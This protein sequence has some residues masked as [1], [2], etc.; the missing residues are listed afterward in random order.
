MKS[1]YLFHAMKNKCS[2]MWHRHNTVHV[3]TKFVNGVTMSI[4]LETVEG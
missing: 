1:T 2:N 3:Q 4:K